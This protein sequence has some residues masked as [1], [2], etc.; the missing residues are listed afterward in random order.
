MMTTML[1]LND[2]A[3]NLLVAP[4]SYGSASWTDEL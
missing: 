1:T 4:T 3:W 2:R